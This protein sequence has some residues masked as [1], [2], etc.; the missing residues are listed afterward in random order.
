MLED[1][2]DLSEGSGDEE[3]TGMHAPKCESI[4]AARL[5]KEQTRTLEAH[6]RAGVE[7]TLAGA[8]FEWSNTCQV[9]VF[10][11]AVPWIGCHGRELRIRG[12]WLV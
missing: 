6:G 2:P 11:K 12:D 10:E 8:M 3:M 1:R 4:D 5:T 9:I 7:D